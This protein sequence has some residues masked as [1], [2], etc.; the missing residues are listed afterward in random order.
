MGATFSAPVLL[1]HPGT[2]PS[3]LGVVLPACFV[4]VL[5]GRLLVFCGGLGLGCPPLLVLPSPALTQVRSDWSLELIERILL[6]GLGFLLLRVLIRVAL[7]QHFCDLLR[8]LWT[9]N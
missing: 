1:C 9:A 4:L 2:P 6:I 8:I 3:W 5:F 7:T